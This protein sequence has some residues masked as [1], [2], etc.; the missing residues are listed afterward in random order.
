MVAQIAVE[1]MQSSCVNRTQFLMFCTIHK[2][3]LSH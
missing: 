3:H 1:N 2:Y